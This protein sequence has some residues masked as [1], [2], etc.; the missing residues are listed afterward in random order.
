MVKKN[1]F[2]MIFGL[3]VMEFVLIILYTPVYGQ[4]S[5]LNSVDQSIN[6]IPVDKNPQGI[7]IDPN[8]HKVYVTNTFPNTVSVINREEGKVVENITGLGGLPSG[9]AID[10]NTHTAYVANSDSNTLS[11]IDG[12][13]NYN[14]LIGL[15]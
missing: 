6:S 1:S 10:P 9:I 15:I 2:V 14:T 12:T 4:Q 13:S 8:T 11:V 3:V 5:K 7:A